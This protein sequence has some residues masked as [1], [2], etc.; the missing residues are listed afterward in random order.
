MPKLV[1]SVETCKYQKSGLCSASSIDVDNSDITIN[2]TMCSTYQCTEYNINKSS[3]HAT[4]E[5]D[6]QCSVEDCVHN[7]N[8]LCNARA[9]KIGGL[10]NTIIC[11]GT[12][13]ESFTLK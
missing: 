2:E 4:N 12:E 3:H 13:C 9:I 8:H 5:I 7:N 1:C 11:D 10:V 6:V